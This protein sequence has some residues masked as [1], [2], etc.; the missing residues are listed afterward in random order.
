MGKVRCAHE[1]EALPPEGQGPVDPLPQNEREQTAPPVI[2]VALEGILRPERR[3]SNHA[4]PY[5]PSAR[6][7]TVDKVRSG[8]PLIDD[9]Q[10]GLALVSAVQRACV[11]L[12]CFTIRI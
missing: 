7:E 9:L 12:V 6:A 5:G 8:T 10:I 11:V 1:L 2:P 4:G 3:I